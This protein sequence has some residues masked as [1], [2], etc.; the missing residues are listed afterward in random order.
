MEV[1][2]VKRPKFDFEDELI[3]V[4]KYKIP[5]RKT[6]TKELQKLANNIQGHINK[7]IIEGKKISFHCLKML[8]SVMY[9]NAILSVSTTYP[10]ITTEIDERNI[11]SFFEKSSLKDKMKNILSKEAEQNADLY[12]YL[13]SKLSIDYNELFRDAENINDDIFYIIK[14]FKKRI[15]STGKTYTKSRRS[16]SRRSKSVQQKK[17]T[18]RRISGKKRSNSVTL[19]SRKSALKKL[20]RTMK[21]KYKTVGGTNDNLIDTV[22]FS[23]KPNYNTFVLLNIVAPFSL[24]TDSL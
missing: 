21:E 12:K 17:S 2:V 1:Q 11:Q 20:R 18:K 6:L 23:Q 10:Y 16:K 5:P 3:N 9:Y 13:D 7:R 15:I 24:F 4:L 22:L 8:I 14:D 19:S